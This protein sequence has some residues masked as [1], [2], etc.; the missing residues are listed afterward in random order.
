[1]ISPNDILSTVINDQKS[2]F[3]LALSIITVAYTRATHFML[4]GDL[5]KLDMSITTTVEIFNHVFVTELLNELS[6]DDCHLTPDTIDL[7][8]QQFKHA[9]ER[10]S[11][12]QSEA[13][14][15]K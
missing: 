8:H 2:E 6:K 11:R 13:L 7:I 4:V 15:V 12:I 10:S 3:R 5:G 1:M 14:S 9:I